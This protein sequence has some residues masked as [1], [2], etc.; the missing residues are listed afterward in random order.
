MSILYS[1]CFPVKGYYRNLIVDIQRN[2]LVFV[3]NQMFRWLKMTKKIKKDISFADEIFDEYN[4]LNELEFFKNFTIDISTR[5]KPISLEFDYPSKISN[6]IIEVNDITINKL[7]D[8]IQIL[9]SFGCYDICFVINSNAHETLSLI[10]NKQNVDFKLHSI[11]LILTEYDDDS[12]SHAVCLDEKYRLI[13]KCIFF[14]YNQSQN[15]IIFEQKNNFEYSNNLYSYDSCGQIA[16]EYFTINLLHF[17][18]SQHHNTCLNRKLCIDKDGYI[19]NCPSMKH[20]YGHISNTNIEDVVNLP[21][22]QKWWHI[23]KDDIDVCK[24]CEFRHMCT[25]CRAYIKDS[26][27]IYSQPAKCPYNPYIC[28]WEGEEGYVPVEECGTYTRETGFVPNKRKI[29]KLNKQIWGE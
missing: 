22:F 9:N 14:N 20:H 11:Q 25:D 3:S 8:L 18:E 6:A 12:F 7:Q 28:K 29:N 13:Q 26:E 21:E 1:C 27:N 24:D 15:D 19:K 2:N 4:T 17:T 10:I 5:I 23:K 16:K